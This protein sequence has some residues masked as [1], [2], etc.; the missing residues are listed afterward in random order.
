MNEKVSNQL[1]ISKRKS[2]SKTRKSDFKSF[3][4]QTKNQK[5]LEIKWLQVL[6]KTHTDSKSPEQEE[7]QKI[8]PSRDIPQFFNRKE[9][10]T[11]W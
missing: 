2:D 8:T 4:N 1:K 5:P 3:K 7:N 10:S 9:K 11:L 6:Q